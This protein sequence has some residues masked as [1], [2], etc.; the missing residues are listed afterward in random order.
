MVLALA[1]G[2]KTESEAPRTRATTPHSP[3]GVPL[4]PTPRPERMPARGGVPGSFG[5]SRVTGP[6]VLRRAGD[7]AGASRGISRRGERPVRDRRAACPGGAGGGAGDRR[8]CQ[9]EARGGLGRSVR[10]P[11]TGRRRRVGCHQPNEDRGGARRRSPHPR[12]SAQ[13]LTSP[14]SRRLSPGCVPGDGVFDGP[15]EPDF[16]ERPSQRTPNAAP[17][18][19][20]PGEPE[21]RLAAARPLGGLAE[22]VLSLCRQGGE[23][24]GMHG[25]TFRKRAGSAPGDPGRGARDDGRECSRGPGPARSESGD[26]RPRGAQDLGRR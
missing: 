7:G 21:A 12:P 14:R 1:T 3:P 26:E 11:S 2:T 16:D 19:E 23:K 20:M 22:L 8:A 10:G 5:R 18:G 4:A 9:R 25:R 17:G 6:T 15:F 13:A 24:Q